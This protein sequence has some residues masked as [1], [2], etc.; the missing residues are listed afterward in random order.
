MDKIDAYEKLKKELDKAH[1][2]WRLA[3][4]RAD[5]L[6]VSFCRK[7]DKVKR[8]EDRWVKELR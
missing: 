4:I 6:Q 3:K 7:Q 8:F 2:E 1:K 5:E